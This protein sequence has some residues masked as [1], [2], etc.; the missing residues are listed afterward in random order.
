MS[1]L[2][3]MNMNG[4]KSL[5]DGSQRILAH[6]LPG[7]TQGVGEIKESSNTHYKLRI[8]CYTLSHWNGPVCIVLLATY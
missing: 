5:K 7:T 8:T 2:T 3:A 4:E 6:V 1:L